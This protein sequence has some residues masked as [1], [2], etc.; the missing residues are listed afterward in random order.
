MNGSAMAT[1]MANQRST[2]ARDVVGPRAV[3]AEVHQWQ[4]RPMLVNNW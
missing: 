1:D 2:A 3:M 4:Q